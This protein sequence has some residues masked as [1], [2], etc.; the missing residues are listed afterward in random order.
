MHALMAC[1]TVLSGRAGTDP[2]LLQYDKTRYSM[3]TSSFSM[4]RDCDP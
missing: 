2:G 1:R 3:Y 4:M